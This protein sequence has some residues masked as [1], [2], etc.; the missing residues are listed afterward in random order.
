MAL[1][2]SDNFEFVEILSNV[3]S[4]W[5]GKSREAENLMREIKNFIGE[6]IFLK[7]QM[8]IKLK[9]TYWEVHKT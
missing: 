6:L 7:L 3:D 8:Q 5:S 4:L 2:F 1:N 9:R